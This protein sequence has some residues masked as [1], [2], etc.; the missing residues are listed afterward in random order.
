[1]SSTGEDRDAPGLFT[2]RSLRKIQFVFLI[3]CALSLIPV[4]TRAISVDQGFKPDPDGDVF[5]LGLQPDGKIVVGGWFETIGG[6]ARPCIARLN[7]DGTVDT[8]FNANSN[9]EYINVLAVQPSDSKILVAGMFN[10]I[11]GDYAYGLVRLNANGSLDTSFI[12]N[13]P[14][15][16]YAVAV[17]RDGKILFAG[18]RG[19]LGD[20]GWSFENVFERLNPDG[21]ADTTFS[22]TA[23]NSVR[24]IALQ[25]DG[26]ILVGGAFSSIGGRSRNRI[27]RFN[28]D[29]SPDEAFNPGADA[30]VSAIAVQPDG[31]ILVGGSFNSIAGGTRTHIARLN[32]SGSLDSSFTSSEDDHVYAVAVQPDGKI[33]IGSESWAVGNVAI[34]RLNPDGSPDTQFDTGRV[35]GSVSVF[36]MQPGGRIL[37]GGALYDQD[38]EG[39]NNLV[40]LA[41]DGS[42]E[43]SF[44]PNATPGNA[45]VYAIAMQP[46][47]KAVVGGD[48]TGLGGGTRN[49]IARLEASASLD[50][51]FNPNA[52]GY[53][54]AIAV[55]S[56]GKIVI[57]GDF[58]NIGG[59]PRS[60][61]ARLNSDGSLDTTFNP[62]PNGQ[63]NALAVQ[64]DGKIL[65]SGDF[66][67][68]AGGTRTRL[69]R[70]NANGSL[71]TTFADPK[72]NSYVLAIALQPDGKILIGG[73]FTTI[74]ATAATAN[75][76]ARLNPNGSVDTNFA[77][78]GLNSFVYAIA[79]QQNGKIVIGGDFT[80]LGG[81]RDRLAR[82][83]ADGSVDS[84]FTSNANYAV[85][86]L[87]LQADGKI[88]VGGRFSTLRGVSR[89]C[90][91]RL[92]SDGL[93]DTSFT[94]GTNN[95]VYA[96][97]IQ[98]DGRILVGGMFTTLGG[99]D[100]SRIGRLS[101]VGLTYQVL[102][103]TPN[104]QAIFWDR[105]GAGAE[106][107]WT[108]FE[109][110]TNQTSW[111]LL[112][113]GSQIP[114][115]WQLTGLSLPLNQ[116]F[117]IRA[118][119]YYSNSTSCSI[120][121]SVQLFY[122]SLRPPVIIRQPV[123]LTV[124]EGTS[125]SFISAADG[126]P[127]PTVQWWVSTGGIWNSI[128]GATSTTYTHTALAAENNYK[129]RAV[130]T[131]SQGS[132]ASDPATLKVK[133]NQTISISQHA[134]PSATYGT[135]LTVTA[136][137]TSSLGVQITSSGVCSGSGTGSATI[138][139]TSGAGTCSVR[140]NQ[141]GNTNYNPAPE[142]IESAT[143]TKSGQTITFAALP[144]RILGDPAFT[145]TATASSALSVSFSSRTLPVCT[146]SGSTV[147]L[148]SAGT[149]TV[150]ASQG[151]NGNYLAAPDVDRSFT[152]SVNSNPVATADTYVIRLGQT[153][154][155][156]APG[157][158]SNDT[159]ANGDSMTA[160]LVS[161]P[162]HGS[163]FTLNADG[164]FSYTQ[165][166][167]DSDDSFTY[168]ARDPRGGESSTVTV[169][170]ALTGRIYVDADAP[171]GGDGRLWATAFKYLQ[172]GLAVAGPTDE[173]W[174]AEGVY[175]PDEGA[176]KTNNDAS[177]SFTMKPGVKIYGGF[178]GTEEDLTERLD[179]N[180]HKSVLSGDIAQDDL[181]TDGNRI[182]ERAWNDIQG[183]N[184]NHLVV[185][186]S[187]DAT[188]R[189]DGFTV[190]AGSSADVGGGISVV[191]SSACFY[192]LEMRGNQA[193]GSGGGMGTRNASPYVENVLFDGNL[194]SSTGG[195]VANLDGGSP[196]LVYVRFSNNQASSG[197]GLSLS[198]G[199]T[200]N[201]NGA[202][203]LGNEATQGGGIESSGVLNVSNGVF[204]GNYAHE[205]GGGLCNGLQAA[206]T[207]LTF[208]GNR[209]G[210]MGGAVAL[211]GSNPT[212]E[213]KS[214]ILWDDA[215]GAPGTEEIAESGTSTTTV[216]Y[217]D[218]AGG[219]AGTG[220]IED[221]P[222][223]VRP[224]TDAA[225]TTVGDLRLQFTSPAIDTGTNTGAPATDLD[226]VTRPFDGDNSGTATCDMGAYE[227]SAFTVTGSA[228]AGG[229]LDASTP[230]PQTAGSP[231]TVSF[232]FN[233][234]ANYHVTAVSGCGGTTYTNSSNAVSSYTY[235]SGPIITSCTVNASFSINTYTLSYAAGPSGAISG[236]SPQTVDHGSD[237]TAVTA[238]P[239]SGYGFAGWSDGSTENPRTDAAVAADV[240]VTAAFAP[241]VVTW[242]DPTPIT[243]GTAL[244]GLQLNASTSVAGSFAYSPA[245][246]TVLGAGGHSLSVTFT[247]TDSVNYTVVNA[248]VSLVVN[249]ATPTIAWANPTAIT[250][251]TSLDGTQ[252][253]A[254]AS[255]PGTFTYSP[256]VGTILTAGS[257]TLGVT[258][259]PT[260][261]ANY[262]SA[263]GSV[264]ITVS[265]GTPTITWTD[266]DPITYGIALSDLQLNAT[267]SVPGIFAYSPD[268][269]T[270]LAAGTHR[271]DVS[272]TPDDSV[273][274]SLATASVT[275]VVNSAGSTI[276]W[277]DPAPILYGTAL[278]GSQLNATAGVAG[279]FVYSPV[280]GTVLPAGNHTLSV[281]FT[282]V[283][284]NYDP[285]TASVTLVVNRARPTITWNQPDPIR[286]GGQL[287]PAQLNARADVPGSFDYSPALGTALPV[288]THTLH[289]TFNP[290][291]SANYESV[292][293]S[294]TLAVLAESGGAGIPTMTEWGI[295]S[296]LMLLGF[297]GIR[298]LRRERGALKS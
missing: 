220:N 123:S 241:I 232:R 234:D 286:V 63:V 210:T 247:P 74:G 266:P 230:S 209:A 172:D 136:T 229:S 228:G 144:N 94:S 70:L 59:V 137:A 33:L 32:A 193:A 16:V 130:F 238:V 83:N 30:D 31:K 277:S 17:Q 14:V 235:T 84:T 252:L 4:D 77:D 50:T 61:L 270:V 184:A 196:N 147:T 227:Y 149:C 239:D 150:R 287:G 48:F 163:A 154:T 129:Y 265:Q 6:V 246:G 90:L 132:T 282:P 186:D 64:P 243:Y 296:L 13:T 49:R 275:L 269:G 198:S 89:D 29:G 46:D 79:V 174:V 211:L 255:V 181:N 143:A 245:A 290:A 260:D 169:T 110:S 19:T 212:L 237:G 256:D 80:G 108:K 116:N 51:T 267:A 88:V 56:D 28:S 65:V 112:G 142:V 2:P 190:T 179:W 72:A 201:M 280:A 293:A 195:G 69:A 126:H 120:L 99:V 35:F 240:S 96:I 254:T 27:A 205:M 67:T 124:T 279:S 26:K 216:S 131:N 23:N 133:R 128:P 288:G 215:A 219:F 44:N 92:N 233:A 151:G 66:T 226:G 225:P 9:G 160:A 242:S 283:S 152:V 192:N 176:G 107:T 22:I 121:E 39:G 24:V 86:A 203:F 281:T 182:A 60:H 217:S 263:T 187:L 122:Q 58:A 284:A 98:Q 21:S 224:V 213:V 134:P 8:G 295:I 91:A 62:G 20:Y 135:N 41:P 221:I 185:A 175:Y 118:R 148:V 114:G 285:A 68:I 259:A 97:T 78:S 236:S 274:Y 292:T 297:I 141:S 253:N 157:V 85:F 289:V 153:L 200:L 189:L 194:A 199:V 101:D 10:E 54:Q 222:V 257:Q 276:T 7:W 52:D 168:K 278:S 155:V 38:G 244:S 37:V 140:Y 34:R 109:Y 53:V 258:F 167:T 273:N 158:L 298:G 113:S 178:V 207:N 71:D 81:T 294:V 268:L 104:G 103:V 100:R 180:A 223:F 127:G 164:G 25:P 262:T 249:Q 145:V 47:G 197:G 93:V 55:Q 12:H 102:K 218:I 272:F 159:D 165:D 162:S 40:R 115:R 202:S 119:G 208:S 173:I 75:R 156:A 117:F 125:V 73:G 11:G 82:L 43:N 264:T 250:Y 106:L 57:G 139:M 111:S 161:G 271:L 248:S 146:L 206:L 166:G 42:F 1:M 291:D 18:W 170:L 76:I 188:A 36:G 261:S 204:L 214:C 251:G 231:A 95:W 177:Q 15:E 5:A 87:A 45:V 138:T 183:T 3:L 171:T 105:N 191:S